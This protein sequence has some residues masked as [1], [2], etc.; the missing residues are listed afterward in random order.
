M[1]SI[2]VRLNRVLE[3]VGTPVNEEQHLYNWDSLEICL[4]NATT[5]PLPLL[6]VCKVKSP[7]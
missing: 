1:T 6:V 2:L 4:V 5:V 3:I 7:M